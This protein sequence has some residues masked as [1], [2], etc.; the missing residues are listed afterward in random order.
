[1][2]GLG[3]RRGPQHTNTNS[4]RDIESPKKTSAK[5]EPEEE[6][7]LFFY[8]EFVTEFGVWY[9][10]LVGRRDIGVSQSSMSKQSHL[11]L[12]PPHTMVSYSRL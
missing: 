12:L 9:I 1:M 6:G 5:S 2:T 3:G 7:K 8:D 10:F 4:S 11:H